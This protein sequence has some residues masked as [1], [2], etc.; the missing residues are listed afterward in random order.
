M[1]NQELRSEVASL[2]EVN[3]ELKAK[4]VTLNKEKVALEK[5]CHQQGVK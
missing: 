1:E 3:G 4:L 2:G 5:K